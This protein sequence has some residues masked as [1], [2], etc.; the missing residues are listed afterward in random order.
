MKAGLAFLLLI[1]AFTSQLTAQKKCNDHIYHQQRLK[2][3]PAL[4]QWMNH[5]ESFIQRQTTEGT[6]ARGEA[7]II[8]IPV[9]IHNLYH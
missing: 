4:A 2:D 6:A 9:V 1:L 3:N 5:A 8:K 7:T